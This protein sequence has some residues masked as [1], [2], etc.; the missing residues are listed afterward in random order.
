MK[1]YCKDC[2]FILNVIFSY[3][4]ET[5]FVCEYSANINDWY[6]NNIQ[7]KYLDSPHELNI[8]N[9]CKWYKE[10]DNI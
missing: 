8:N 7:R 10:K 4:V 3:K 1:V 9:D 2:K 6:G 5:G